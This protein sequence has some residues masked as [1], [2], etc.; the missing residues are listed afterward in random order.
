MKSN[1]PRLLG[2]IA[3]LALIGVK[4]AAA[5]SPF[6]F[7][8]ATA[9]ADFVPE[10]AELEILW[11]EGGFTEGPVADED[12]TILFSDIKIDSEVGNR[13]LRYIPNTGKVETYREPSGQANGLIFD[14]KHRLIAAEG[15][16]GGGR[17]VSITEAD[18]TVR[19]LA[20]KYD[21]KRFNSPND[22][23]VDE[24]G[25]VYFTDPRYV[26]DEERELDFEAVYVIGA[27]DKLSIATKDVQKPNGI[28]VSPDQKT[29]YVADAAPEGNQQLL[30][31]KVN[32]DG[33]L[34][35]KKVLFDFGE[36]HR[37]IDGM[38]VNARGEIFA[39]AGKGSESAIY[40]LSP[41][42]KPLALIPLPAPP[43]NCEFGRGKRASTLYIT[44]EMPNGKYGLYRIKLKDRS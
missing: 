9:Q 2:T 6:E 18:G 33:T 14:A 35:D 23:A 32:D 39:A 19:T 8:R 7:F 16:V 24:Q 26:G 40:V 13:I 3:L 20:D 25:R 43:T 4:R 27:G 17:R 28:V 12:G 41:K 44:G 31:F 29:V 30:A 34:K 22:V 1:L 38:T 42:G 10:N 11:Q 21:G 36:D 5:Q 37:G 15:A